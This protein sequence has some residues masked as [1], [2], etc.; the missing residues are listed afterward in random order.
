[1]KKMTVA[2]QQRQLQPRLRLWGAVAAMALAAGSLVAQGPAVR[3][4]AEIND[5]Q[6]TVLPGSKH[7]LALAQ[8]DAGRVPADTKLAG[9][10]IFFNRSPQQEADLKALIQAQQT[11][12]S[13]QYHQWLTPDQFAVRF[14]MADADL[15][16]VQGWLEREGFAVD[17]INRSRNAIHFTGSVAQVEQAFS[18]QMHYYMVQGVK[19]FAPSTALSVPAAMAPVVSSVMNLNDFKPRPMHIKGKPAKAKPNYTFCG[20]QTCSTANQGVLFAPGDIKKVYD[21]DTPIAAGN[22]GTGQTIAIMGQSAISTTD[23]ENFQQAA[24]LTVKDPVVT[25]VPGTGTSTTEAGDES[26]SDLD[27]EWSGA[28]AT[29]AT[30]N[31][32]YTG[33]NQNYGVFDSYQ[34]AVDNKIGNIISLSYGS[35]ETQLDST[36]FSTMESW[37]EQAT[38][39]GQTVISASGDSGAT[40]C[41]GYTGTTDGGTT[42]TTAM[43]DAEAVNYPASS[44]YVTGVGGTEITPANDAVG[45]YWTSATTTDPNGI[46]LESATQYIPEIAWNDDSIS[47]NT[48]DNPNCSS[49]YS[50][51]SASGGGVSTL[52][53]RPSWQANVPGIPSGTLR[54]VPDIALYASPEYPGYLYCTSDT[55][56]WQQGQGGTC[57]AGEFYDDTGDGSFTVAGGTSFAAPIFAGE[58]AIVNQA[59]GWTT[60]QGLVN[61]ELYT[62]ASNSATYS[63]AFHDVTSGTNA[64]TGSSAC[65]STSGFSA[66][67]GYDEV[68]GL[69][70]LDVNNLITAWPAST[71]TLIGTTTAV[72]ASNTAPSVNQ[73][74]SFTITVSAASGTTAPT[75]TVAVSVDGTAVSGSPFTLASN[76]TYVYST[77]FPTAGTHSVTA[78]YAG[79]TTFGS[80][81]GSAT[82]NVAAV[83]S[84]SGT[85]ALAATPSTLTVA[86][87]Q[88]GTETVAV[89]PSNGYTGTVLL[90]LDFGTSGDNSLQNLCGGFATDYNNTGY[91]YVTIS[92]ANTAASTTLTLDTNAADCSTAD[93]VKR[94]GMQKL[95][96]LMGRHTVAK[97][98][99]PNLLPEGIAFAGLLAIGFIG[100]RSRKLRGLVAVLLLATVGMALSACGSS[101]ANTTVPNPPQGTYT[102]TIQAQD[103][104]TATIT[105]TTTFSFVIN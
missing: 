60:G 15:Q 78:N 4:S 59:K 21:I 25:L 64:C 49:T 92:T 102:G 68:T 28:T 1:M 87:G 97:S 47:Y 3:I 53:S 82:V 67:T 26:E 62:L 45:T 11:P 55:T 12:G 50:C 54:L 77:S 2:F 37:G 98:T 71:S 73:S 85:I 18:T 44:A 105:A 41:Y 74:V 81:E 65:P 33:S 84:G 66:G 80:S 89:T 6:Q 86:Q 5:G 72:S 101:N 13:P 94:T 61:T 90:D 57:A 10:T 96:V 35:C 52:T 24:A 76:G 51:L 48:T 75:G 99:K 43:Q 32:V 23:I 8:L 103:S 100:R 91:G 42:W 69:G 29:G 19:H 27:I 46:L 16:K 39:Q 104:V 79:D 9:V 58:L 36:D 17:S 14:G 93:A 70:S 56:A 30:I 20:D 40:A 88:S 22:N 7:P 31:F 34:Y 95:S 83:S 63:T 38:S